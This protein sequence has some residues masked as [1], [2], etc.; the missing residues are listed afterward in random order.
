[1]GIGE[2]VG[3]G[4]AVEGEENGVSHQAW[5][6]QVEKPVLD[7]LITGAALRFNVK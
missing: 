6:V 3:G 5:H 1:M 4:V 2:G 7:V